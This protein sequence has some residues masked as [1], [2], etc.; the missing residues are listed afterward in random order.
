MADNVTYIAAAYVVTWIVLIGYAI[1]LHGV[2]RRA[3]A[4]YEEASRPG[5]GS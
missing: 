1:R 4:Q 5:R 3:R 2:S